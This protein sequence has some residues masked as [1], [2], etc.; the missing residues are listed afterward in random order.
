MLLLLLLTMLI[1]APST[2]VVACFASCDSVTSS[3]VWFGPSRSL[4]LFSDWV[5]A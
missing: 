1:A 5:N 4:L 2:E 3:Q